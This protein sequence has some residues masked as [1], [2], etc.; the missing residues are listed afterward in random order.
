MNLLWVHFVY[1]YKCLIQI[2]YSLSRLSFF[3]LLFVLGVL[4]IVG[5]FVLVLRSED[6]PVEPVDEVR[7]RCSGLVAFQQVRAD[8]VVPLLTN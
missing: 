8:Y 2:H 1:Q 7:L 4:V 5:F 3:F 6:T